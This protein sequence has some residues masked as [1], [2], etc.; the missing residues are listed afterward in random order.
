MPSNELTN[1]QKI[2]ILTSYQQN[3]MVHPLTCGINSNHQ[4]LI[5]IEENDEVILRCLDCSYTQLLND[6]FIKSLRDLDKSY[7][8]LMKEYKEMMQIQKENKYETI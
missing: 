3:K 4:N 7:R 2:K 5:P 1:K 6:E 8:K